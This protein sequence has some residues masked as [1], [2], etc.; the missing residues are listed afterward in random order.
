[1][2]R[3]GH[4]VNAEAFDIVDG[5]IERRDF[6]FAPVAGTGIHLADGERAAQGLTDDL[7]DFAA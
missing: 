3:R 5:I 1:M 4:E 7:A 6:H 2:A